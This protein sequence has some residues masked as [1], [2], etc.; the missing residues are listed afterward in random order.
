MKKNYILILVFLTLFSCDK[1]KNQS[2]DQNNEILISGRVLFSKRNIIPSNLKIQTISS[3]QNLT[4]EY[5]EIPT[6]PRGFEFILDDNN[7]IIFANRKYPG[8][9]ENRISAKSTALFL[10]TFNSTFYKLD[11]SEKEEI[12]N[13]IISNQNFIDAV[14]IINNQTNINIKDELFLNKLSIVS[15]QIFSELIFNRSSNTLAPVTS[16]ELQ[17]N[18]ISI[19]NQAPFHV[20][21][22]VYKQ[23]VPVD[24]TVLA[25][26]ETYNYQIPEENIQNIFKIRSGMVS[27]SSL[28]SIDAFE[29]DYKNFLWETISFMTFNLLDNGC[30]ETVYSAIFGDVDF[31]NEYEN[32]NNDINQTIASSLSLFKNN[33]IDVVD[34]DCFNFDLSNFENI[35]EILNNLNLIVDAYDFFNSA[36]VFLEYDLYEKNYDLCYI[37]LNNITY[38]CNNSPII[39][40][41]HTPNPSDNSL[42][43]PLSGNLSF[44]PGQNTPN[45][46]TYRLYF[47]TTPNPTI[48]HNLSNTSY[49]YSGAL[50]NTTYYWK[51]ETISNLGNILATSPIWHFTTLT[52]SSNTIPTV[53][54][55]SVS[56]ITQNSAT[57]GGSVT[58]NGG[59]AVSTRGV[60][61]GTSPNPTISNNHTINGSGQGNFTSSITG[62]SANTQY[63][64]RAY[65]TNS[66]GTAYGTQ[67]VFTTL[68]SSSNT[69]PTVSTNS[70]SNIT[71]NSA[72][73]GGNVTYNGGSYVSTRGVCWSTSPNPT[74]SNNHT[75]NGSGQGNFTSSI[76]GLSANTQYYVRAYA[77]NSVGT[78][79]GTQRVFTTQNNGSPNLIISE[80]DIDDDTGGGSNGNNSGTLDAGE[81]IELHIR[82]QNN[83]NITAHNV[84]AYLSTNDI[85]VNI[86]DDDEGYNDISPN[87]GEEWSDS[88]FDFI[89]DNTHP[90]GQIHFTL[91][92]VSDEGS[93]YENLYIDVQGQ[94]SNNPISI[95]PTDGCSSSPI[96]QV[97]TEYIVNLNLATSNIQYWQPIDGHSAGGNN[98]QGFYLSFQ[99]PSNWGP[100]HDVKIYDVSTNFNPVFGIKANCNGGYLGQD[101]GNGG[102]NDYIDDAGLGGNETSDT[103][104]PGGNN[105]GTPDSIYHIRIYHYDGSQQP[106]IS[107]KIKIE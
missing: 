86:T 11:D 27:E 106:N 4:D 52:Y 84:R 3:S 6:D 58:N 40:P 45:N 2:D 37:T 44:T 87:G 54:T 15:K 14:E 38:E 25:P 47:G 18:N 48:H 78:A 75:V 101:D 41:C 23:T 73:S 107:F 96:M 89:I 13:Q 30:L 56:N 55:N 61:W 57:S 85:G 76:S 20:G 92:I 9:E 36:Y 50:E 62:L 24:N 35:L 53:S 71:Q 95:T 102:F 104:L 105:G 12:I 5:I 93:W 97:N 10:T 34:S 21:I 39:Q 77:T 70:V 90:T 88:D 98:V 7:R 1:D 103:N 43:I 99:V 74:I 94:N 49:T 67:R 42:N 31:Y 63:Y 68:T 33:F 59:S 64:V 46:A 91:H 26:E 82:L 17:N 80:F 22:D 83:G 32:N 16:T 28:A 8:Y 60:C 65:A 66:I 81:D 19:T 69:I 51:V 72:T 79:Y 29:E 100:N